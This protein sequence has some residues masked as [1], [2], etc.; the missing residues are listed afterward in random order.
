MIEGREEKNQN[1]DE[2]DFDSLDREL[3]DDPG[4]L[5]VA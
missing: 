1:L 5:K 2:P 3:L 4:E